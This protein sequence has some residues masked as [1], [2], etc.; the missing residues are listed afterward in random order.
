VRGERAHRLPQPPAVGQVLLGAHP[1][2]S[3]ILHVAEVSVGKAS[4]AKP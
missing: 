1:A 2:R 4:G 3:R